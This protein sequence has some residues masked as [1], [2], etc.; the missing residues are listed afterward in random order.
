MWIKLLSNHNSKKI[1]GTE[2]NS[3]MEK[4]KTS[5]EKYYKLLIKTGL[6]DGFNSFGK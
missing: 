6:Q 1:E 4:W 5:N 3:F 2:I